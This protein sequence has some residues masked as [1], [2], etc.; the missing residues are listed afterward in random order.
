MRERERVGRPM[1]ATR[2]LGRPLDDRRRGV[3]ENPREEGEKE[4]KRARRSMM[5]VD[6]PRVLHRIEARGL[7]PVVTS[8]W[9]GK[10]T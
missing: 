3:R 5:V 7:V 2:G 9:V 10:K 8:L 1:V 6:L 4:R